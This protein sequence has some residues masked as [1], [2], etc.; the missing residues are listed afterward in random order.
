MAIQVSD[1]EMTSDVTRHTAKLVKLP[2]P[3]TGYSWQ[4]TWLPGQHLSRNEAITAMTIA[5]TV[6]AHEFKPV[7]TEPGD[8]DPVWLHI[9]R[10]AAELGIT[11]PQAVAK[12]SLSPEDF[13]EDDEHPNAK[14]SMRA[15]DGEGS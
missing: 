4:V 11:A 14:D 7:G 13:T 12:A 6:A 1:T 5:E 8:V 10:W 9:D 3:L 15:A 2:P